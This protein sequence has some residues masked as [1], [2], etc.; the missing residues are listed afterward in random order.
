MFSVQLPDNGKLKQLYT[1]IPQKWTVKLCL[2]RTMILLHPLCTGKSSCRKTKN[3]MITS[4]ILEKTKS[5]PKKSN[6]KKSLL[7]QGRS[8]F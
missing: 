5:K 6:K 2:F 4:S 7:D 8:V 3:T 1:L